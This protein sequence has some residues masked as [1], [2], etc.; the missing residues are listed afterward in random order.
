MVRRCC[1]VTPAGVM[2]WCAGEAI[3]TAW[4]AVLVDALSRCVVRPAQPALRPCQGVLWITY[5]WREE[6]SERRGSL[7][8][9]RLDRHAHCTGRRSWS[10]RPGSLGTALTRGALVVLGAEVRQLSVPVRGL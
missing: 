10:A 4:E 2:E 5:A 3:I 6:R 7:Y 1:P 9:T 8:G